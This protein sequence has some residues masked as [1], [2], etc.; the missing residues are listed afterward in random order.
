MKSNVKHTGTV[1]ADDLNKQTHTSTPSEFKHKKVKQ[2]QNADPEKQI[3]A[4]IAVKL[5]LKIEFMDGSQ[6]TVIVLERG[7]YTL[8]VESEGQQPYLIYKHSLKAIRPAA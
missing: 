7:C 2:R 5:P 4:A 6:S 1:C 8:L 3:D